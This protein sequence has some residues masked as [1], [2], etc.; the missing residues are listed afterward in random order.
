MVRAHGIDLVD[1]LV[2]RH[3]L[4]DDQLQE[5]VRGR[6]SGEQLEFLVDRA[7]PQHDHA[8]RD[9][10]NQSSLDSVHGCMG[11][12]GLTITAPVGS[13]H[14]ASLL[15]PADM[16]IP[17]PFV[18]NGYEPS[19]KPMLTKP[20]DEQIVP[21]VLPE[22]MHLAGFLAQA[23]AVEEE[24]EFGACDDIGS[25]PWARQSDV[26]WV[27]TECS[28]HGGDGRDVQFLQLP[29]GCDKVPHRLDDDDEIDG[30]HPKYEASE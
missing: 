8:R 17:A 3:R 7:R 26:G 1:L 14:Q 9:L 30:A 23:P 25:A 4:I 22:H 11:I 15:P 18:R 20:V 16:R 10:V 5:I 27:R 2:E 29:V 13:S 24:H 6:L 19:D 28:A 21:V 12:R